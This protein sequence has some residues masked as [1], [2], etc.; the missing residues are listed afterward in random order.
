MRQE[1]EIQHSHCIRNVHLSWT[2][3]GL[4]CHGKE[5]LAKEACR[6]PAYLCNDY[7]NPHLAGW[8]KAGPSLPGRTFLDRLVSSGSDCLSV[9][10][11]MVSV[12]LLW[13]IKQFSASNL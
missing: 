9:A 11:W 7:E 8:R 6:M 3:V 13:G 4:K 2:P 1:G 5:F 10:L 12:P